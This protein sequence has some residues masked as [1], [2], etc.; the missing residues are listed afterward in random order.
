MHTTIKTALR[1]LGFAIGLAALAYFAITAI[2]QFSSLPPITWGAGTFLA[3]AGAILANCGALMLSGYAW[4]LLLRLYAAP[5]RTA[6]G[7]AVFILA[8]FARYL[9]GNIAHYAGR[10]VLGK[11]CSIPAA[12]AAMSL[13][14]EIGWALITAAS[15]AAACFG[16]ADAVLPPALAAFLPSWLH[17]LLPGAAFAV[18]IIGAAGFWLWQRFRH[19]SGTQ[20]GGRTLLSCLASCFGLY[21]ITFLLI[22]LAGDALAAGIFGAKESHLVLLTGAF[23]ASWIAGLLAFGAPAGIGVREV[24]LLELL[25]PAFGPAVA[26]GLAIAL[27]AASIAADG[28]MFVTA[29][30]LARKSSFFTGASNE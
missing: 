16:M 17:A 2:Q 10:V 15:V 9:P 20:A 1:W 18:P 12:A 25:S 11:S 30:T 24:V 5:V 14:I 27:R 23:A 29:Y 22:G 28:L 19:G 4:C 21:S 7:I 8:Q 13:L 3:L 26:G 6:N